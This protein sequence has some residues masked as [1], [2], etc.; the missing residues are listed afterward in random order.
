VI[1]PGYRPYEPQLVPV[2]AAENVWTV[3][4]PEIGYAIGGMSLPCP[5]RMTIVRLGGSALWLHSPV[6]YSPDLAAQVAKLGEVAFVVAPN[7]YHHVHTADWCVAFPMAQLHAS[8]DLVARSRP[9]FDRASVLRQGTPAEWAGDIRTLIVDLGTFVEA[10]FFHQPSR[11]LVMTDL[12]QNFEANRVRHWLSRV[13]LRVGGATGPDGAPSMEIRIK[14]IGRRA[15]V[16]AVR[17]AILD[18]APERIILAHGGCYKENAM[19]EVRRAFR[20]VG[21]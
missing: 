1:A 14:A 19:E 7:T 16:R 4:G 6:C 20:W 13:L 3:E 12:M 5:T 15:R 18:W 8:Y 2:Q 11:T 9:P 21:R 17:D 10:V